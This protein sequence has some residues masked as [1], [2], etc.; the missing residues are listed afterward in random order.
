MWARPRPLH[1]VILY[2]KSGFSAK[3]RTI[4]VDTNREQRK[5]VNQ[6]RERQT[7][8]I[9]TTSATTIFV[10]KTTR[11]VIKKNCEYQ[12]KE[13]QQK[14]A[15]FGGIAPI[16]ID[17]FS[18]FFSSFLSQAFERVLLLTSKTHMTRRHTHTH[19]VT[20]RCAELLSIS[21][22]LLYVC[23]RAYARTHLFCIL[24]QSLFGF[25]FLFYS[26]HFDWFA[27]HWTRAAFF[28]AEYVLSSLKCHQ[29]EQM[30]QMI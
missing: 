16:P 8:T 7:T 30:N 21:H 18:F 13:K 12:A 28:S 11:T 2:K 3:K 14:N 25:L 10:M 4:Q 23:V 29:T 24:Y 26:L 1:S 20:F 5:A 22:Q 17:L 6:H 9:I 19:C 15:H 27:T